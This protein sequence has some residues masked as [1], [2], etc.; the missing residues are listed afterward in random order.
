MLPNLDEQAAAQ[1]YDQAAQTVI[2]TLFDNNA[3]PSSKKGRSRLRLR[4]Y[5]L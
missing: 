4:S 2:Q 5:K 1:A 3:I